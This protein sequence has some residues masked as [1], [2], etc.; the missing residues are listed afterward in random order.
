VQGGGAAGRAQEA[1]GGAAGGLGHRRR[2]GVPFYGAVQGHARLAA[3]A[4]AARPDG[5]RRASAGGPGG[6]GWASRLGPLG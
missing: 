3:A 2:L 1:Q 4:M 5:P 6:P